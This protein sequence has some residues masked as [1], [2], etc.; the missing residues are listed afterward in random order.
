MIAYSAKEARQNFDM[1]LD[2]V[3]DQP[4]VI[5]QEDRD[6]AVLISPKEYARLHLLN[7]ERLLACCEQA[8]EEAK[9]NGLTEEILADLLAT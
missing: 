9:T 2:A 5:R 1:L 8:G 3:A 6:V 4:V 7:V